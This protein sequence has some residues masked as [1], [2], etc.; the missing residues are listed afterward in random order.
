MM[1]RFISVLLGQIV[2]VFGGADVLANSSVTVKDLRCEYRVNPPAIDV[3][4]PR[5]SW[6]LQSNQRGQK[7]TAYQL[8]VAS[9]EKTLNQ[10]KADLFDSGRVNSDQSTHVV[11]RAKPLKSRMQCH[12]KVR[13][14]DKDNK[15]SAWS[16]PAFWTMGLMDA[17]DW[18]AKWIGYDAA[19]PPCYMQAKPELTLP[20]PAYLR[21]AFSADK[22]VKRATVYASAMGIY[23]LHINGK[24]VGDDYFTPGWSDY[25]KRLYYHSYDVTGLLQPAGNTIA[26]I[27]ADGW[28]AGYVGWSR[29]RQH[30]GSKTRV[31]V[32][33]EVEYLDGSTQIIVSDESWKAAYGPHIE[34]DLLMGETYDAR[35]EMTGWDSPGFDD[36]AWGKVAFN[37][38]RTGQLHSYPGVSVGKIQQIEPVK[39]TEPAKGKYTFDMGQNFSGWVRL[40]VKGKAGDKIV[41][42]FAERLNPDGTVYTTNLRGARATDTY[43]C[44]GGEE[45][46]WQPSFTYHGFQYVE[47]T[48]YPGRPTPDAITGIAISSRTPVVGSFKCSDEMAN[49]LYS[50]IYW[51]QRDNFIDVP[52]DCPQRDERLGWT[53]DAQVFIRA[54]TCNADVAAFFTKWLIDLEDGQS[55]EGAFPDVAPRKV[56]MAEGVGAWGD[57]GV[58]CPWTIYQVYGDRR[59]IR[60]HYKAMAKWIDYCTKHSRNLLRPAERHGDWLSIGA[61]TPTDVLATAY[62]ANSTKLMARTA[63]ALGKT[64]DAEKYNRLLEQIKQAF[65]NAY[66]TDDGRIKGDTQTT[67]VLALAF[68]L[69][70]QEMRTLAARYLVEDIEKRRWHL[71][72]G[73]IGTKDLMMVLTHIGRSD[74]AYRLFHNDTFPSWGF[75]IRHGATTIW[76]RWDG[77]TPEKGFQNYEMNS[78]NHYSFGAVADWMFKTVGGIDTN[79]PGYK[80]IIIR[81]QP[82]GKL[83][84]AKVSY[85]SIHGKIATHWRLEQ[86]ALLK[87]DVTIPANTTATV[88]VPAKSAD[89]VIESGRAAAQADNVSFIKMQDGSAVFNIASGTYHFVSQLPHKN[90]T[91]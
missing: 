18:Q 30:Y 27:L 43:I 12:W 89:T 68:D 48:G 77:W 54:A 63:E 49:K 64:A 83:R 40:K 23:E 10:N 1:R 53:G 26:A 34:A 74:V 25:P 61:D 3:A 31:L 14:W 81:P 62:F 87:L 75:S 41:L 51:T 52:T 57:A 4:E 82:G 70:A 22:P 59:A 86:P 55:A 47:V 50:N 24:R 16:E 56:T 42:R 71:S 66:V 13:I 91:P 33:L 46:I 85:K 65:N 19:P 90:L 15:A 2:L 38:P 78:F 6:I 72:T 20:P 37:E 29:R 88:Y 84:F 32:Q 28:Y 9:S 69:L 58:I 67:Y 5:L 17:N 45:E 44:R 11:Y 21:K 35:K 7:Q 79:G 76:E 39:L 8:L 60:K 73:F 80:R 36:S